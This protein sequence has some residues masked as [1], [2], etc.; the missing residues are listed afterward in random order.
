MS[1]D[2][3]GRLAGATRAEMGALIGEDGRPLTGS[4]GDAEA[5]AVLADGSMLVAFERRHRT[6]HYPEAS[7]PFS[8]PPVP[9]PIPE[10]LDEAPPNAGL[11]ALALSGAASSSPSPSA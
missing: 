8:K 2:R 9:F 1:Y 7:P 11:E 6:L 10:G 4:D 5:L 3:A